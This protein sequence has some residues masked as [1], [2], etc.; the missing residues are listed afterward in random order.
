MATKRITISVPVEVAKRIRV[1]AGKSHSIS[2]WVASAVERTLEDEDVKLRFI[3][4]CVQTP[5]SEEDERKVGQAFDRIR[6]GTAP[7]R[8]TAARSPVRA[9][10]RKAA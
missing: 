6:K 8:G 1:A 9:S 4:W 7:S 10:R 5:A 3:A 2:E